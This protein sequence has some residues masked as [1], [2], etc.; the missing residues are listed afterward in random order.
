MIV[1]NQVGKGTYWR[2]FHLGRCLAHRGHSVTLMA[3]SPTARLRLHEREVDG[4]HL[5][6]TPDLL[7]GPL[8]S[9]WDLWDAF[10]RIAWLNGRT[11]DIVHAFEARPVVL[12]PALAAQRRGAKLVMDWCDWFGRGGSVEERPSR[13]ARFI[14]RFVETYFE[15]R[16][17][18][19]AEGTTVINSVLRERAIGL[20]VRPESI[21]LIRNGS[22]T[23]VVP[24]ERLTARRILGLPLH[25]PLIGFVGG[26]YQ[27]DA[28][29][30]ASALNRVQQTAPDVRLLLVGY[31]NRRIEAWL[32]DPSAVMRT[33]VI[34]SEQLYQYLASCEVCW[35]PLCN[36]GANRGRWPLKLNDYMTV[37]RPVV[38][39]EVGDLGEVIREHHL[40]VVTPDNADSFAEQTLTLLN[41]GERRESVGRAARR[42]AEDVFNW[43]RLAG[44]LEV[45]YRRVVAFH[46]H[47][48]GA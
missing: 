42:A 15:E 1:F 7:S 14:L 44:D 48:Q 5:V 43:E 40:G 11:F 33:G 9:G 3:M 26:I 35:L 2:A 37:G 38:A 45:F 34:S 25:T 46:T 47:V 13:I 19:R 23:S 27:R 20:G 30:M 17:R 28:E 8:R 16:F 4:I 41:D 6:E 22:N 10:R 29:L 24:L 18:V 32:D 36:S 12:M 39:T 21:L 31:F